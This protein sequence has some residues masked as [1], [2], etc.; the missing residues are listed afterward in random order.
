MTLVIAVSAPVSARPET[1]FEALTESPGLSSFW[2]GDSRAQ[3]IVGSVTR[4][5]PSSSSRLELRVDE[6]VQARRVVWTPLTDL[7]RPPHWKGTTITWSLDVTEDGD[8]GVT[9]QHGSW[10]NDLPRAELGQLT[11]LWA[12]VLGSLKD[13]VETGRPQPIIPPRTACED[14]VVS[15][16]LA[17]HVGASAK[18]L[19]KA[20]T[21]SAGLASFWTTDSEA[22]PVAGSVAR[23]GFPSGSKIELRVDELDPGRRV[24]WTLL[25]DVLR[26]PRWTRTTVRWDLTP[27]ADRLTLVV[28]HQDGW[29]QETAQPELAGLTYNWARILQALKG[30]A[31]TGRP[32][33]HFVVAAPSRS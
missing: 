16:A 6:L 15:I 18:T 8:T 20:L 11:V 26:G 30:Y 31:E 23:F 22:Q 13:F 5:E 12:R 21:E 17:T 29:P 32:Q 19:F 7:A 2:V 24:A 1:I 4:L 27:I 28:F 14:T 33:P 9:V 3:P 25:N 10:S